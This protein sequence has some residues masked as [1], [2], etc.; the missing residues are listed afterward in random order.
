MQRLARSTGALSGALVALLGLWGAI[1]PFVGPYFDY[2]F[3]SNVTWHYTTDRL[4][5]SIL[6]G[7]AAIVGGL[8]LVGAASRIAGMLGGW[9]AVLAGLWFAV[10]PAFSRIWEHG[11]GPIGAPTGGHVRQ[12]LELVGYFHGLGA[13]IVAFAAVAV[14]RF[15]SRPPVVVAPEGEPSAAAPPQATR[16]A[17]RRVGWRRPAPVR[18]Q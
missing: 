3:G 6:P 4:V 8:L 14:G 5:L 16:H 18:D 7:A 12:A 13:L 2:S 15:A 11:A 9:L 10:G 1:I 17:G